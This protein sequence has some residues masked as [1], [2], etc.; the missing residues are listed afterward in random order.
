MLIFGLSSSVW[1]CAICRFFH[2]LF[3]GNIIVAK[4]MMADITDKTN[5]A[6]AFSL[7]SLS[8][9]IGFL[10]GPALGG[11]LY[12][13]TNSAS[14]SWVGFDKNGIFAKYT[15]LLPSLVICTYTCFCICVCTLF[16][17]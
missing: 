2:G 8:T 16:L 5:Q 10:I 17:K 4:T 12:D 6:K 14:L 11:L 7:M 13:P 1:M 15:A 9:G 3:N